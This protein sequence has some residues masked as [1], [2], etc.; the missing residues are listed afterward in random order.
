METLDDTSAR[1][2]KNLEERTGKS[3]AAW[4][5]IARKLGTDKHS[6]I[7]AYLKLEGPM[8]H[9]Y[10]NMIAHEARKPDAVIEEDPIDLLFAGPKIVLR[11]IYEAI[12]KTVN[13]FGKDIELVPKKT[14][15]SLRRT[16]QFAL[17]QPST[18]TRLDIGIHL[19]GVAPTGKLEASGTWNGM[20]SHRV[21]IASLDDFDL[22]VKVWLKQAYDQAGIAD[23]VATSPTSS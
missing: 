9:G 8:G 2:R 7:V 12:I 17:V 1:M 13:T 11:P 23:S 4:I 5:N 16:K 19:K 22:D 10:A 3:F 21:R 14:N 18:A 15:V 20:V 6:D